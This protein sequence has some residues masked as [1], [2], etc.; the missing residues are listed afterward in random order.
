MESILP[1]LSKVIEFLELDAQQ[2]EETDP[3]LEEVNKTLKV[4]NRYKD[5]LNE[6]QI[7]ES[8]LLQNSNF[9]TSVE[10]S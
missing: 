10:N 6:T 9:D 1:S 4:L 3:Y 5:E 2:L 8:H 7:R